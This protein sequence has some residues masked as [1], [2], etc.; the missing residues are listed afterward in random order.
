M[1]EQPAG[2]DNETDDPGSQ[3]QSMTRKGYLQGTHR[4]VAPQ[5]TVARMT[6]LM[7]VFGITRIANVTGL[8]I[9]GLPVVMVCRPNSRSLAVSQGK[10]L[11]LDAARASGLMESIEL[12]HG[13]RIMSP[14]KLATYN[15]L[16][17]THHVVDPGTLCQVNVSAFHAEH[18]ILW[19]AGHDLISG[20]TVWTPYECVHM[21]CTLP[22]PPGSGC[23]VMSSN[24]LASG[25]HYLEAVCHALCEVVERDASALWSFAGKQAQAATRVDLD[26][27]DDEGCRTVLELYERADI[28]AAVWDMTSDVA[29][30]CFRC[31]I[32]DRE[33]RSLRPLY[34]TY[35]MGCHPSRSVALMRALTEAA[36]SRLTLISSARD[37]VSR[38]DYELSRNPDV[39]ARV[40]R[41]FAAEKPVRSFHAAPSCDSEIFE[42]DLAWCLE[43]LR[44][45]GI[46]QVLAFDL[47]KPEL[48]IPVVRV[49]IPGLEG[50]HTLPGYAPGARAQAVLRQAE[51]KQG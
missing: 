13:E 44:R 31:T 28:E 37:D 30:P 24:G 32:V 19:I 1:P 21:N 29:I 42:I 6:P 7:P 33:E 39:L 35:G 12:Y 10:G 11:D 8:D 25:N 48:N 34:S 23:F 9:I 16:R 22:F 26:T 3:L 2:G 20:S 51:A 27:I 50:N 45:A 47:T 38:G 40:R 46:M 5:E 4:L 49:V 15:E 18:R 36:Q 14:L 41:S 17:Y 43:R